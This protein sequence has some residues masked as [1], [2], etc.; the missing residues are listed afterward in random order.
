METLELT[1][2]YEEF[3]A[4]QELDYILESIDR[5]IED[6]L[7]KGGPPGRGGRPSAS[8]I[9]ISGVRSG[10]ITLLIVAGTAVSTY[11]GQRFAKGAKKGQLGKEVE[12][13]GKTV[14]DGLG[15]LIAPINAWG[16]R[17]VAKARDEGSNLRQV[18]AESPKK[19]GSPKR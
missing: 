13:L 17:Y 3:I 1:I 7:L 16:E 19:K 12:R 4:R 10:S 14:S 15:K 11:L 8:Y 5:I 18:K 6:T 2:D 9:A